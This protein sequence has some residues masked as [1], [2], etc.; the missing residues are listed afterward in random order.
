[1][2]FQHVPITTSTTTRPT[3]QEVW[4]R[5]YTAA[6]VCPLLRDPVATADMAVQLYRA[7]CGG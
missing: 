3:E 6:V 1:M 5:V 7:R 4:M 2:E